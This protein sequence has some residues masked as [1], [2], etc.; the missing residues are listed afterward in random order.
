MILARELSLAD[1]ER[2]KQGTSLPVEVFVHGALCVAYS[3]QCLTK[4]EA[5]GG[6]SCS[7]S[8]PVQRSTCRMPYELI[9]DGR[10]RD[11]GEYAYLLSPQ[12]LA[13]HD[14]IGELARLGVASLKIE[15]RLKSAQYVAVTTQ[16]LPCGGSTH[17]VGVEALRGFRAAAT[18]LGA[19]ASRAV[20]RPAFWKGSTTSGWSTAAFLRAAASRSARWSAAPVAAC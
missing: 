5:L 2:V 10:R 7:G 11:L 3:G 12:D 16:D 6:R 18:R 4:G 9:V 13:A 17:G 19:K 14:L 1:I 15:G 20:S 8:R